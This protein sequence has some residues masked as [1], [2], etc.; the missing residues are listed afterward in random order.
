[1]ASKPLTEFVGAVVY[2]GKSDAL[3]EEALKLLVKNDV[4]DCTKYRVCRVCASVAGL[5]A[6]AR[7][8][9]FEESSF[10]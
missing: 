5:S 4:Q 7:A 9:P 1:M 8:S 10:A 3:V 2:K 6:R